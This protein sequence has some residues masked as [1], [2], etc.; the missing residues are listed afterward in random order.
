MNKVFEHQQQYIHN[1]S[2]TNKSNP[3]LN[4]Y[5]KPNKQTKN[6]NIE[7]LNQQKNQNHSPIWRCGELVFSSMVLGLALVFF[8]VICTDL[9]LSF[10][11][12]LSPSNQSLSLSSH[13][14]FNLSF[15][16]FDL[17]NDSSL[18]SNLT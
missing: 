8:D 1:P 15:S 13:S 9:S 10:V 11:L 17:N 6:T 12:A 3:L 2:Q 5:H 18:L 16:L 7:T 14:S 4:K